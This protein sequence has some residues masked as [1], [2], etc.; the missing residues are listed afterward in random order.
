MDYREAFE[1]LHERYGVRTLRTDCG[2]TLNG[3]LLR[4]SLVDE[5][6]VLV[7]PSLV[8]GHT[9][10]SLPFV[11]APDPTAPDD[12]LRLRLLDVE[13]V[14]GDVLWLRYQVIRSS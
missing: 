11:D 12:V 4:A 14:K 7:N 1:Q 6:S 3:V 10:A 2:G 8:G 13:R 9:R 5:L